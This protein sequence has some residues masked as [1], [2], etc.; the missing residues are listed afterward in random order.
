MI[1]SRHMKDRTADGGNLP[2]G[3]GKTPIKE[4]LQLMRKEKWAFPGDIELE[5]PVP[6][7]STSVAEVAK[8][9]QY[10]RGALA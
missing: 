8:G 9:L 3:Q 4:I 7:G 2:W 6:A 10:C 1:V 5:Y